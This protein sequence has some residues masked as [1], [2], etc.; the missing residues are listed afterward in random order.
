MKRK[1][2]IDNANIRPG[3]VIMTFLRT[4]RLLMKPNI[5]AE[6]VLSKR[7]WPVMMYLQNIWLK[8]LVRINVPEE[9][10]YTGKC[11]LTDCVE[12]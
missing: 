4:D 12:E 5:M 8:I 1:D 10:V 7:L 11:L 2:V 9:L 3:D 6:W